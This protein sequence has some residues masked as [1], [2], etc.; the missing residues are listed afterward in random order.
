[1][2][3]VKGVYQKVEFAASWFVWIGLGL[4]AL[5]FFISPRKLLSVVVVLGVGALAYFA[6]RH[7]NNVAPDQVLRLV[8]ESLQ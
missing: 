2:K 1:M 7:F 6:W 3:T 8:L 4:L 5:G